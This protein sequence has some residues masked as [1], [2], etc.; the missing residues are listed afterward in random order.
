MGDDGLRSVGA[1]EQSPRG[2]IDSM[3]NSPNELT[4]QQAEI[5]RRMGL[6]SSDP[7]H[8]NW[9]T[10]PGELVGGQDMALATSTDPAL[11][12]AF[13]PEKAANFRTLE[14]AFKD[15]LGVPQSSG[16]TDDIMTQSEQLY[17]AKYDAVRDAITQPVTIPEQFHDV[18]TDGLGRMN[19]RLIDP[20]Q[21]LT[22]EQLFTVRRGASQQ[23]TKAAQAGDGTAV[24]EYAQL[25]DFINAEME[26]QLSGEQLALL[27]E[28]NGNFR[29]RLLLD[30]GQVFGK[31][32]QVNLRTAASYAD[33]IYGK[34]YRGLGPKPGLQPAETRL[35]DLLKTASSF[36]QSVGN[37]GTA[38]RQLS[39][40]R[41]GR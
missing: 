29:T 30:S 31:D 14:A 12:E 24:E 26:A 25:V 22:A 1:A 4:D 34:R 18:A 6:P 13:A 28:A 33:K 27:Q 2:F 41:M 9:Q 11:I 32:G 16:F 35:L 39:V 15:G 8:I 20:T 3:V 17:G 38:A 23:A 21:P 5:A 37:S 10:V 40:R 19:K 7:N 36:P